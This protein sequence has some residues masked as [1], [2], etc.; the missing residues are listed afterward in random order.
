MA[1]SIQTNTNS[2]IAQ[3]NLRVNSDFQA[4]TIQRLT[5]GFRINASGDDAAGL[6]VANKFRSDVSELTQGVRNANDGLSTLQIVDGGLNNISKMLDR[7]QTLATQSASATFSGNRTTLNNEYQDLLKEIDRQAANV[8]LSNGSWGGR[9]NSNISVYTGGGGDTQ[10]NSKVTISLAGA[11]NRVDSTGLL[12]SGSTVAAGGATKMTNSET[13]L[14]TKTDFLVNGGAADSQTFKFHIATAGT[15]SFDVDVTVTGSTTGISGS[16]VVSQLNAGLTQYGINASIASTGELQFSG[17]VA[18]TASVANAAGA[19]GLTSAAGKVSNDAMYSVSGKGSAFNLGTTGTG[20]EALRF[21]VGSQIVNV[22]LDEALGDNNID[23][24]LHKLNA[25]LNPLGI[26]AVKDVDAG[27]TWSNIKF[28]STATFKSQVVSQSTA[29]EGIFNAATGALAD[30]AAPSGAVGSVTS[31]A[32][33]A[34]TKITAA[35]KA[36][37]LVQGVVGTAQNKLQYA[38]N[39][40][41]SQISNFAAADSRIRDADVASEAANLTKAQVLQQASMA[42]MAQANSAPQAVLALL[43]G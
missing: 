3:E 5:S 11:S 2:L 30:A 24:A 9:Y 8:G 12:L 15:N 31:A 25:A 28:E 4:K 36:L 18:F 21:Q 41:Q 16:E 32:E 13:T 20:T 29:T 43:R 34:N 39:L 14:L 17:D 40:A 7:L 23:T 19:N 35:V 22:T 38:I 37:G 27:A 1:L 6:A 42:A 10:A 26:Y 33:T